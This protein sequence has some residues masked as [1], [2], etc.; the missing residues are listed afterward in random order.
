MDVYTSTTMNGVNDLLTPSGGQ[1]GVAFCAL[2]SG[3]KLL[4][5]LA[6]PNRRI[7]GEHC[8]LEFSSHRRTKLLSGIAEGSRP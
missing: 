3:F 2:S 7:G 8:L 6:L 5:W 1:G 4:G